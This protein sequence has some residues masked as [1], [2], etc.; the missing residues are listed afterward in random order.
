LTLDYISALRQH[1]SQR[2]F[3]HGFLWWDFTY[4][5]LATEGSNAVTAFVTATNG[6]VNFGGTVGAL[7][8]WGASAATWADAATQWLVAQERGADPDA[9]AA[10]SGHDRSPA[11]PSR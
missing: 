10:R 7:T 1:R 11:T 3:G 5:T 6:G 4:P 2:Q 8:A 9:R